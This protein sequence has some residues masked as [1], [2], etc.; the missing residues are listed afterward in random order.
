VVADVGFHNLYL[1][2]NIVWIYFLFYRLKKHP[3]ELVT[4]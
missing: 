3:I 1:T 2:W 4:H